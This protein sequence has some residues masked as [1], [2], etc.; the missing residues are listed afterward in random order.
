MLNADT[1]PL[2]MQILA[3]FF[4]AG[5]SSCLWGQ[6]ETYFRSESGNW[7]TG[8]NW[9]DG[10]PNSEDIARFWSGSYPE[11]Q[12]ITIDSN[13][14]AGKLIFEDALPDSGFDFTDDILTVRFKGVNKPTLAVEYAIGL[15]SIYELVDVK[16]TGLNIEL[17]TGIDFGSFNGSN[18]YT[19]GP[20][21]NRIKFSLVD[22]TLRTD[23]PT[24]IDGPAYNTAVSLSNS[25]WR[26]ISDDSA[27]EDGFLNLADGSS[28]SLTKGS[29]M[30][31][32][33]ANIGVTSVSG[34]A[35]ITGSTSHTG[36]I[37]L[38]PGS[39]LIFG[40]QDDTR[41]KSAGVSGNVQGDGAIVVNGPN[42]HVFFTGSKS[43]TGGIYLRDGQF[44]ANSG[45]ATGGL[46]NFMVFDGGTFNANGFSSVLPMTFESGGGTINTSETFTSKGNWSGTG[47]FSKTGDGTLNVNGFNQGFSGDVQVAGGTLVFENAAAV[48][49]TNAISV[50]SGATMQFSESG[51]FVFDGVSGAG[52][53]KMQSNSTLGIGMNNSS[54][55]FSGSL[56]GEDGFLTK[57]GGGTLTVS[58]DLTG[59]SGT[60]TVTS[61]RVDFAGNDAL[62]QDVDLNVRSGASVATFGSFMVGELS[63]D[64]RFMLIGSDDNE[65]QISENDTFTGEF[66]LRNGTLQAAPHTGGSTKFRGG[67][68]RVTETADDWSGGIDIQSTGNKF[69]ISGGTTITLTGAFTGQG[70][71]TKSGGGELHF[72]G[73]SSSFAG[74]LTVAEGSV[75]AFGSRLGQSSSV[76]SVAS[77]AEL[78]LYAES[79]PL[80]FDGELNGLGNVYKA[81]SGELAFNGDAT[82]LQ[83]DF[84]VMD[85][86][87]SGSGQFNR[88]TVEDGA[89]LAI[90]NSPGIV[91]FEDLV[92]ESGSM[93]EI[94]LGGLLP[95]TEY[96]QFIVA[97]DASIFGD[98]SV[99]LINGFELSAGQQFLIGD[100]G[101]GLTGQFAGLN[102]GGLVGTFGDHDLFVSYRSGRGNSI[103]L[104]TAVP[105]PSSAL[106]VGLGT[107]LFTRRRLRIP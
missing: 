71:L 16:F 58:G 82:N 12:T 18:D 17:P 106:L 105:E 29:R 84:T 42:Y 2:Q 3:I 66:L 45:P 51:A 67:T 86:T 13:A 10:V 90:G 25:V 11:T 75:R 100:I 53:I 31:V 104:F 15:Q 56:E 19:T 61:G 72:Q 23:Y 5:L 35:S 78:E 81:G 87:L 44:T 102:E 50:E 49:G 74:T 70:D 95:G 22:S 64:G 40:Q 91:T 26:D 69:D 103:S 97:G 52:T 8:A 34:T 107:L 94:E 79:V 20:T 21:G 89:A 24:G 30:A 62:H 48:G 76:F 1:R 37:E 99:S 33:F 27:A 88:L 68:Y 96:D 73:D 43:F 54:S 7:H 6:G 36:S 101:G 65:V 80:H 57:L 4:V 28:L 32:D 93:L 98:L 59:F 14:S 85:G 55:E 92:L 41:N 9:T 60:A 77:Q 63:G 38:S 39:T 47:Q 83:G 46:D